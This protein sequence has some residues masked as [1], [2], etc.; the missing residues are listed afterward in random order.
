[1]GDQI[2]S[3][4]PQEHPQVLESVRDCKECGQESGEHLDAQ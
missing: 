1:M 3:V 4:F 2:L